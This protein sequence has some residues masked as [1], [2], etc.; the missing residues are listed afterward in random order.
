MTALLDRRRVTLALDNFTTPLKAD[1]PAEV[2]AVDGQGQP[3]LVRKPVGSGAAFVLGAFL[4]KSYVQ[5]RNEGLERLIEHI[6]ADAGAQPD[7][8]ISADDAQPGLQWRC[9][10]SGDRN[11]LWIINS[12]EARKMMV[13]SRAGRFD[14]VSRAQELVS[15]SAVSVDRGQALVRLPASGF[16]VLCW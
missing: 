15:G 14:G 12:G 7:F 1:G 6:C 11:L 13:T 5:N 4:G 2:L 16:A 8:E 10:R 9:G 3:L